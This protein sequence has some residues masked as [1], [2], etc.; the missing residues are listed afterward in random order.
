MKTEIYH[1][2]LGAVKTTEMVDRKDCCSQCEID[3]FVQQTFMTRDLSAGETYL[4]FNADGN[5][6]ASGQLKEGMWG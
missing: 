3:R 1:K 4:V 2:A 6:T 5:I